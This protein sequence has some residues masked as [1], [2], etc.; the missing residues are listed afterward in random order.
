MEW[1]DIDIT[2][3]LGKEAAKTILA[4]D[5]YL[6]ACDK[7]KKTKKFSNAK[8]NEFDL[9]ESIASQQDIEPV[10]SLSPE[11]PEQ[12]RTLTHSFIKRPV[13]IFIWIIV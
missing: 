10:R 3:D 13:S 5:Y 1:S 4:L 2:D 7:E 12:Y 9:N 11:I 6:K 8:L